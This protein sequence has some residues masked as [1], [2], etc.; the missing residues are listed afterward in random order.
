MIDLHT[1]ILPQ[2]DDGPSDWEDALAL[3]RQGIQDGIRGA[4]C[5]SH[6]LN[7]LD[8]NLEGKLTY[9]FDQLKEM[10]AKHN[11]KFSLW[12]GSEL[13]I[14][15]DFDPMSQVATINGNKKRTS[16]RTKENKPKLLA[17]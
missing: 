17:Q 12:L 1:H 6:V 4:V 7:K 15:S 2:V 13:H 16:K 8:D 3:I 9:R 11:L 14:L 5:T 10:I